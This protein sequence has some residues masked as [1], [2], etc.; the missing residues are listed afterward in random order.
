[1]KSPIL[2]S[3]LVFLGHILAWFQSNSAILLKNITS[4]P[5]I[6]SFIL[7][8]A[9]G[10]IFAYATKYLYS[11]TGSIWSVRFISFCIGYFVFI[12][13]SWYFYNESPLTLKNIICTL[14]CI[15]IL[16]VQYLMK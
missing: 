5:I 15:S 10:L 2:I 9:S 3:A 11:L 12:P 1:M 14:L 8:P 6:S 13:L 4:A 7:A 16:M